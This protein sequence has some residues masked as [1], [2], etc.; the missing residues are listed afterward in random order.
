MRTLSRSFS[1]GEITPELYGRLDLNSYQ[2][3]LS[4]CRNFIVLPH[5]PV[6]NRPGTEFVREVKDSTKRTRLIPFAYSTTQT[7]V[8]EFGQSYIRFHTNGGTLLLAGNPYEVATPYLEAD[9]FDIHY[10]QSADVMTLVHPNYA[11]RELRRLGATSWQLAT[12]TFASSSVYFGGLVAATAVNLTLPARPPAPKF[13]TVLS[14]SPGADDVT[15][16]VT[17]IVEDAR[18]EGVSIQQSWIGT[19]LSQP[20]HIEWGAV[21]D[22]IGYR[23]YREETPGQ[24]FLIAETTALQ[25]DDD[26]TAANHDI[27]IAGFPPT[28]NQADHEYVVTAIAGDGQESIASSVV[29]A[30]SDLTYPGSYIVVAPTIGALPLLYVRYNVYKKKSGVFGYIGSAARGENFVDDN[31]EPDLT[32]QPPIDVNPFPSVTNY[33]QAVSYFEQR[34]LFA[35]TINLPQSLWGTRTG[36]ESN[37]NTN[38]VV[39]DD[40]A[41]SFRI[42]AREANTIRHIVPLGEAILLTSSAVWRVS[43]SDGGALTPS[44]LS[45]KPQSYTGASNVQPVTTDSSILYAQARGGHVREIVYTRSDNGSVGY[46]NMDMSLLSPHLFKYKTLV[47]IAFAK[48]PQPILWAVSSDGRL[49]GMTYVPDQKVAAWH[50][51]DTDGLF[52]SCTVVTEGEEDMLYLVVRRTIG[53]IS[54]RYVERL[55]TRQFQTLQDAFFVDCGDTYSGAATTTISGLGHLEGKTVAVLGN[56]AVLSPKVVTGG[57]ITLE[58][59]VTV[60]Q[61]GLPIT[62][63]MVTLPMSTEQLPAAGQGRAKNV[64]KVYI[65]VFES[66]IVKAGPDATKLREYK[67]RTTEPYGSPPNLIPEREI[68]ITMS[69][70]WGS[71][72]KVMVRQSSPL[73]LT[74]LSISLDTTTGS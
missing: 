74:V 25:F 43:S 14:G 68:D 35:G 48:A 1:G 41:I 38:V 65:R 10:V 30:N 54:R 55:H 59:A 37:F 19:D 71:D 26:Q 23:L 9:L 64:N 18:V 56:G 60:A 12:I 51:H 32:R 3:G 39:R 50:R 17:A 66:S 7:M 67:Q 5:G 15:Y 34:R 6:A 63:D 47:D 46:S 2:T 11:P 52:E 20:Q 57:A 45:V 69:P 61:V 53:A 16:R 13:M 36:T 27:P 40:D 8:L 21:G 24:F 42:A 22:A 49:L 72:A 31:I 62:S 44:T 33:P 58:K 29:S 70:S 73:P 4:T 28:P